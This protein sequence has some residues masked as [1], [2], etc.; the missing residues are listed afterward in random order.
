M[1]VQFQVQSLIL[2]PERVR[3]PHFLISQ[4]LLKKKDLEVEKFTWK[5]SE[6]AGSKEGETQM[7]TYDT[8]YLMC[9]HAALSL[10]A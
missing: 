10:I 7:Y 1:F 2:M 8:C 9:T 3:K 5:E 4:I 6:K